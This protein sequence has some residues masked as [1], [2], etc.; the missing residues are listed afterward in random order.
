[1]LDA[2]SFSIASYPPSTVIFS[3]HNGRFYH[4][5]N[6]NLKP[7]VGLTRFCVL[8]NLCEKKRVSANK[9]NH[10]RSNRKTRDLETAKKLFL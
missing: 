1:M 10:F 7:T 6:R 3:T 4:L 8:M 2:W 5:E 9:I